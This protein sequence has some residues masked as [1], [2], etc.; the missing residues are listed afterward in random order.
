MLKYLKVGDWHKEWIEEC[1]IHFLAQKHD[2][3]I[4]MLIMVLRS[5]CKLFAPYCDEFFDYYEK[6]KFFK[7]F[8]ILRTILIQCSGAL[9]RDDKNQYTNRYIVE[10][11]ILNLGELVSQGV[12][13]QEM[14]MIFTGIAKLNINFSVIEDLAK[15]IKS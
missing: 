8:N 9:F 3:A 13:N 6:G 2:K 12:E 10:S 4:R 5:R 14:S 7:A 15:I 11:T 1:K